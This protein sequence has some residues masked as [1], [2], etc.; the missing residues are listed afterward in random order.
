M[1][2]PINKKELIKEGFETYV[3]NN[4]N[5][6]SAQIIKYKYRDKFLYQPW[7]VNKFN[8]LIGNRV[9]Y[10]SIEIAKEAIDKYE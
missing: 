10:W 9:G 3:S 7:I 2:E 6:L 8:I 1:K 5:V 4:P